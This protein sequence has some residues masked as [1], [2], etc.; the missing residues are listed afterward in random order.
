M[1]VGARDA[2]REEWNRRVEEML[3]TGR[4]RVSDVTDDPFGPGRR[5][6]R[7]AQMHEGVP[8]FGG[9]LTRQL[10]GQR[11]LAI[12]GTLYTG[13]HLR[14]IPQLT[15]EDAARMLEEL[16]GLAPHTAPLPEL[17]I[18]PIDDGTYRLAYRA[19]IVTRSDA[20]MYFVDANSGQ[21]LLAFSDLR[22]PVM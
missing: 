4:L 15:P 21:V 11:T 1:L 12:F 6:E 3:V 13:V 20:I 14:T 16:A 10:E 8:V 18:L 2:T 22:R 19:R 7:L 17:V 9:T 5:T